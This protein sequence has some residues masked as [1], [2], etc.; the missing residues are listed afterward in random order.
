M[1]WYRVGKWPKEA[2]TSASFPILEN[3]DSVSQYFGANLYTWPNLILLPIFHLLRSLSTGHFC[4]ETMVPSEEHELGG[5]KAHRKHRWVGVFPILLR[6]MQSSPEWSSTNGYPIRPMG[7]S[8]T[9][10]PRMPSTSSRSWCWSTPFTSRYSKWLWRDPEIF[11]LYFQFTF[12]HT[13]RH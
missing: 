4:L 13:I 10:C 6:K 3:E 8:L 1:P 9:W 11:L 5:Q 7:V 12:F 2:P